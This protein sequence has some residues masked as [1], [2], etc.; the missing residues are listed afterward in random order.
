MVHC[1]TEQIFRKLPL[2]RFTMRD[3]E[4][5]TTPLETKAFHLM[6]S[7]QIVAKAPDSAERLC[8]KLCLDKMPL[9]LFK[10]ATIPR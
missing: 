2:A 4:K 8:V 3:V 9:R 7:H 5:V 1:A 6:L 10:C